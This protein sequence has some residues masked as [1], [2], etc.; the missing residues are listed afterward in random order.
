M[1]PLAVVDTLVVVSALA[2][3]DHAPNYQLLR[4][5]ATGE[6]LMALSDDCLKELSTVVGYPEVES[7]IHSPARAFRLALDIGLTGVFYPRLTHYDWPSVTDPGDGWMLDLA[8]QAHADCIVTKDRHLTEAE[9]P[10]PIEV[11]EPKQLLAR[12]EWGA[13]DES[14]EQE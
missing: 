3:S 13:F 9:M 10:F 11:L 14:I 6:V 7:R 4:A 2:G 12:L 1:A 8:W 5:A